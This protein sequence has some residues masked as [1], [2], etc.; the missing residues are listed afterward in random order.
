MC[1]PD[2]SSSPMRKAGPGSGKSGGAATNEEVVGGACSLDPRP[3]SPFFTGQFSSLCGGRG[4]GRG[5]DNNGG[6]P[7][8][9]TVSGAKPNIP[10]V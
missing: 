3:P 2:S 6:V 10:L 1:T 5:D 4:G 8:L 7:N 9:L